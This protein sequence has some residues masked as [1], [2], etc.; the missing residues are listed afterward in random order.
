L[1]TRLVGRPP[2]RSV[3]CLPGWLAAH[4]VGRPPVQSVGWPPVRSVGWPPIR[5]VGR[6]PSGWSVGPPSGQSATQPVSWLPAR[7][8][9]HP[10]GCLDAR[11]VSCLF[12]WSAAH[13]VGHPSGPVHQRPF[14]KN[15]FVLKQF[16]YYFAFIP[17]S[18]YLNAFSPSGH[19]WWCKL[20]L[21]RRWIV[22]IR[23]LPNHGIHYQDQADDL[24]NDSCFFS[25]LPR[26]PPSM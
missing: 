15:I 9:A 23:H 17:L 10:V 12:G 13:P 11:P 5:S 22:S 14:C 25:A 18:F 6:P 26:M 2:A 3:G 24:R 21:I 20:L 16:F 1:A 19:I 4:K 7:S 8:A